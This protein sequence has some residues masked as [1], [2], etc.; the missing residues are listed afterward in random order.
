MLN[1]TISEPN[2]FNLC[3][4]VFFKV[5]CT[6]YV[7]FSLKFSFSEPDIAVPTWSTQMYAR[8]LGY[9][10]KNLGSRDAKTEK[11]PIS[12]D[13]VIKISDFGMVTMFRFKRKPRLLDEK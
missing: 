6:T 13:G 8:Q 10:I 3:V 7:I 11:L 12:G 2:Q 9:G 1:Q 5:S 4:K